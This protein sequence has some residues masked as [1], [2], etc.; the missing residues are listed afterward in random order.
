MPKSPSLTA[1]NANTYN[2]QAAKPIQKTFEKV[3]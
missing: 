1:C 3:V 2:V